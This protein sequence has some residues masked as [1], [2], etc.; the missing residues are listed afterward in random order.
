[1]PVRTAAKTHREYDVVVVGSGAA[2][3][4]TAYTLAMA[5]AKVV[6]LEAGRSYDPTTETPMFQT[7]ANAPLLGAST[8]DKPFGFHDATV[9]GGWT[10][11]GEP[12]MTRSYPE[13]DGKWGEGGAWNRNWV[14]WRSRML[15]GRTNH[16]GRISLRLG[17]YDFQPRSRDGLGFDWPIGYEDIADYYDKVEM[18]IGV[19]GTNEG[20]E[21]TP[22]SSPGVLLPAPALRA[23][24][25][26][27]R[28]RA[29]KLGVPIIPVH[30][31]VLTQQ[32][33]HETIPAKLHPGDARAQRLLA[34][35]MK[36]RLACFWATPC[37][38]GCAIKATYQ[39]PAVHLPPALASGDLD[40]I[41]D[42]VAWRV[43][44]GA[45][46]R[47]TGV[48]YI[49]RKTGKEERVR[50]RVIALAA[51]ACESARILL[52][53]EGLA[54]SSGLVGRYLMDSVGSSLRGQIPA[55]E[56]LPPHDEDGAGGSHAYAPW[57]LYG[58][59][60]KGELDFARGYHLEIDQAR[61]MPGMWT[62]GGL[63]N[64]T[65][66]S[67]GK[68]LKEDARR[69]YGSFLWIS[70]R[71]EMIPNEHTY[72]ELD[73]STK[74]R[75]GI[76]VLRFHS[77]WSEHELGQAAHMQKTIAEIYA[78]MGGA[79]CTPPRTEGIKAIDPPGAIIHEVGT[80]RMGKTA[81]DS[82]VNQWGQCWDVPNLFVTDGGVFVSNADK[83]PTLT[84]MALAWRSAD[85]MLEEMRKGNL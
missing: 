82:V 58:A 57:W 37:G 80:T 10:V 68:Q 71:G 13:D 23:G 81:K 69:Y 18:L 20:L 62:F 26:L 33:D 42:A 75:Y 48:V 11:P 24:E 45:D 21:N 31:A 51:G 28:A 7:S 43:E 72:C 65:G 78:A 16:W 76:P 53:S 66:G 60:R 1:M 12:Y 15:G 14:W 56:G 3:G 67:Y 19:Y 64:Y 38:R 6:M 29:K 39:S 17:P 8:P 5:G 40:V 70:G 85:Y 54:N 2:G 49:D 46:G 22:D 84:I 73:P 27:A 34:D 59:Q 35:A 9:D 32:L 63:E 4:Q 44:T 79:P 30:R 74:D 61:G 55:L 83:N 36:Q 50:G 25:Q 52:N 47:A 41:S 77:R